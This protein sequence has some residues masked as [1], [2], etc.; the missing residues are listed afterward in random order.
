MGTTISGDNSVSAVGF[1]EQD[2]AFNINIAMTLKGG[3]GERRKL[4]SYGEQLG[5]IENSS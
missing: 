1:F 5:K 2:L 4:F 3:S